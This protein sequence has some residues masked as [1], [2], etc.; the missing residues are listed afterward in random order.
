MMKRVAIVKQLHSNK[1]SNNKNKTKTEKSSQRK[2]LESLVE[3]LFFLHLSWITV[4]V[5][6]C[7]LLSTEKS[8]QGDQWLYKEI[9]ALFCLLFNFQMDLW[10][11]PGQAI[12]L[13]LSHGIVVISSFMCGLTLRLV[14]L[15]DIGQFQNLFGRIRIYLH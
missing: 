10:I 2:H 14:F 6:F 8:V 9:H 12:H 11:H 7:T 13:L 5:L 4:L 15:L 1:K 3:S